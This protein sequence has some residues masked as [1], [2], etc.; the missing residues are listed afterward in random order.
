M[1]ATIKCV[2]GEASALSGPAGIGQVEPPPYPDEVSAV[3]GQRPPGEERT[4][5]HIGQEILQALSRGDGGRI[6]EL[7]NELIQ[8]HERLP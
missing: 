4:E 5:V 7:A 3:T 2:L 6:E 1:N 8:M